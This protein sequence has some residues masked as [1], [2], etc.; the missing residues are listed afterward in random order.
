M[1][2]QPREPE[3][4]PFGLLYAW[5]RGDALPG[6]PALP[7]FA[8]EPLDDP[9]L[10][11]A[12]TG[13]D[14]D[15]LRARR[16]AGHQTYVARVRGELAGYG[17]SAAR[18]ASIGSLGISFAIPTDA[19][20]LWDFVTRPAWR[21]RGICPRLLQAIVGAEGDTWRFW[22]G[23]DFPNT[24]S[25]RGILKAGFQLVGALYVT[26]AAPAPAAPLALLPR[27]PLVR[28]EAGAALLGVPL[29]PRGPRGSPRDT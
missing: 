7:G 27:G 11:Q 3:D 12:A 24:A 14:M 16:D 1:P 18:T 15:D 19:R 10:A 8:A 17:W 26:S 21:G 20:Y 5:W 29:L 9:E 2:G 6:L 4:A 13:L 28:A 25:A 23:H 22:I